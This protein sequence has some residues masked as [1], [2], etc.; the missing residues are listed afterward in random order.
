MDSS[1]KSLSVVLDPS[2]VQLVVVLRL[3]GIC[4][5]KSYIQSR[6]SSVSLRHYHSFHEFLEKPI[7]YRNPSSFILFVKTILVYKI[8]Y[9]L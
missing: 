9:I 5:K 8:V 2:L 7:S 6:P 1:V 3:T 4:N